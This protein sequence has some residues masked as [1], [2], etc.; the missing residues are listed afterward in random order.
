MKAAIL[1]VDTAIYQ[2]AKDNPNTA[3]LKRVL[4][5]AGVSVVMEK[6]IPKDFDVVKAVVARVVEEGIAELVITIGG[7]GCQAEE[8]VPEASREIIDREVPGIAESMRAYMMRTDRSAMLLRGCAGIKNNAV[9][10]NL[11]DSTKAMK[12]VMEYILPE[13]VRLLE[14]L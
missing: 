10:L 2:G 12:E 4:E 5:Q 7:I 3:I 8:C 11:P 6:A 14:Q 9:I 13:V 1:P